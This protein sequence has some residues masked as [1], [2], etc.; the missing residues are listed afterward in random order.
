MIGGR[1]C[2]ALAVGGVC[3]VQWQLVWL[4]LPRR[5]PEDKPCYSGRPQADAVGRLLDAQSQLVRLAVQW[6]LVVRAV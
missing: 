3:A 6:Q 4:D 2:H 1:A 5:I